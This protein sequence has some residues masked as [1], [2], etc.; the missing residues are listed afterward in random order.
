ML[1]VFALVRCGTA[2]RSASECGASAGRVRGE[3]G[4]SAARAIQ[5]IRCA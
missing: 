2:R 1:A 4:A 5:A 3:C